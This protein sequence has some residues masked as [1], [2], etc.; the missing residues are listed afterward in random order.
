[1][2]DRPNGELNCWKLSLAHLRPYKSYTW[3]VYICESHSTPLDV[4]NLIFKARFTRFRGLSGLT[5]S[6]RCYTLE[7][8]EKRRKEIGKGTTEPIRNKVIIGEAK[9]FLKV[10]RNLEY[11]VI[12]QLDK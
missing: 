5:R 4:L 11:S 9:E 1:M 12:Q 3:I 8:L 7:K 6:G 10:I 2:R